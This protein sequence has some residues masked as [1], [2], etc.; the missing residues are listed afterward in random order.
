MNNKEWLLTLNEKQKRRRYKAGKIPTF[1][2]YG[3][4]NHLTRKWVKD[5]VSSSPKKA[6][7]A[8]FKKIGNDAYKWRYSV[9][10]FCELNPET[11]T[12]KRTTYSPKRE[13]GLVIIKKSI[14]RNI[15]K[16]CMEWLSKEA[17]E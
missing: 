11:M 2:I 1:A 4:Y 9:D 8:L 5:I 13:E 14:I 3:V 6:T 12:W 17:L 16:K 7:D 10:K 15:E